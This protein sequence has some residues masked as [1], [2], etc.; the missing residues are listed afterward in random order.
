MHATVIDLT[1]FCRGEDPGGENGVHDVE[2]TDSLWGR[3]IGIVEFNG[4][5]DPREEDS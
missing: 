2:V 5:V 4:G 3:D 1:S